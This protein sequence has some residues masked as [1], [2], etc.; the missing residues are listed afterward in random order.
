MEYV[1]IL[2]VD[3]VYTKDA[4]IVSLTVTIENEL[5][6]FT[7]TS[8]RHP[9]DKPN[10]KLAHMIAYARAYENLSYNLT[11]RAKGRMKHVEDVKAM[12]QKGS[13]FKRLKTSA[14]AKKNVAQPSL[15]D[16]P[17]TSNPSGLNHSLADHYRSS[18]DFIPGKKSFLPKKSTE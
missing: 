3:S 11:K 2:D 16:H 6:I 5:Y 13:A 12:K 8:R 15:F 9:D 10:E 18:K 17:S 4:C 1:D 14:T 7:G